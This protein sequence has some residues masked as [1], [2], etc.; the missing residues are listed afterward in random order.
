MTPT[1]P[2]DPTPT[3]PEAPT[4]WLRPAVDLRQA[5]DGALVA[6]LD[7]PGV[8]K[9][10]L[11]LTVEDRTLTVR[12]PRSEAIG[13]RFTLQLPDAVDPERTE[14]KLADGVLSITLRRSASAEPRRITVA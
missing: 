14:A 1:T 7:V 6:Y 12:A 4:R 10:S 8:K 5:D 13:Y 3:R 2:T 9:E 11:R